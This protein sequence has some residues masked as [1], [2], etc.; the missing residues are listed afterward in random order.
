MMHIRL[1]EKSFAPP[2]QHANATCRN[3]VG[4][5]MSRAFAHRVAMCCDMLGVVGS[6]LKMI[7]FE[8]TTP[9]MSQH[10]GQTY[11]T[12]CAQQCCDMLRWPGLKDVRAHSNCTSL[13]RTLFIKH[14][15]ATSCISSSRT[16]PSRNST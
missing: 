8:S 6:D 12:C 7:K 2:L 1:F 15:L 4:R 3:I 11:A 10:D 13:V 16:A 9:N 5:N 14:E